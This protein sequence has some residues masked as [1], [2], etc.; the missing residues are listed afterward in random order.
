M[1]HDRRTGVSTPGLQ[2]TLRAAVQRRDRAA[3]DGELLAR[4]VARRDEAA[5]AELVRRH[6][7]MVLGVC[8]RLLGHQQDAEDAFQATFLPP[9]ARPMS[10]SL[11]M[12]RNTSRPLG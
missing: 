4:F 9:P 10:V 7:P 8:R 2:R 12:P 3:A 5:F 1:A 11:F 6:G